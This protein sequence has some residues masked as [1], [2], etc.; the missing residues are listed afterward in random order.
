MTRRRSG[1]A[2]LWYLASLA[3]VLLLWELLP[4]VGFVSPRL[5]PPVTTVL[6]RLIGDTRSG[7]M[8][9][10]LGSSAR[11]FALG[12][13][14]A[15]VL[16][17]P[18]GLLLGSVPLL[19]A[20][21]SPYILSLYAMP[22]QAWFPLLIIW[23]GIGMLSRV[24]LIA[25]FVFFAVVLNARAGVRAVDSSLRKVGAV[26]GASPSETLW[27]ITL[28][29]SLPYIVVGLRLGVGRGVIGVFLAEL[30]GTF[31]GVGY[32]VF[33]SGNEFQ[34]DRVF[35]GLIVLVGFSLLITEALRLVEDRLAPW[36]PH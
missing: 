4:R 10:H 34:L 7:D 8:L 3:G 28:P 33:R 5:L 35:A 14:I 25:I 23:F 18:V 22:S 6:A 17:V 26:F 2:V 11:E 12:Y 1:E 19:D 32:Y 15:A 20:A 21:L 27:K 16:A 29:S 9:W 24:A 36:T 30:V 31:Q 13:G